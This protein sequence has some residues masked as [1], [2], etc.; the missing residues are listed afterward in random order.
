MRPELWRRAE[1]L[2]HS[3]LKQPPEARRAFLYRACGED[4]E[5]RRQ[6]ELLISAEENAGS[7][8]GETGVAAPNAT[9][10]AAGSLVGRQ[11]GHY[12]ITASLGAGG[13]GE[14]YRAHD[15]K[16]SRDVAIKTLP[17]EFARDGDRVARFR[18]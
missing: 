2:F 14:V 17:N 16:L 5:L 9:I 18:R 1:E 6:V 4:S 11:L 12:R 7:F 10:R 13:M 8:L 3:A 15:T